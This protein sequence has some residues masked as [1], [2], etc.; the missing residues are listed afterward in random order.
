MNNKETILSFL[1]IETGASKSYGSNKF[2]FENEERAKIDYDDSHQKSWT[3]KESGETNPPKASIALVAD[4]LNLQKQNIPPLFRYFLDGSR[5]TYK[6]DD[7]AYNNKI[8]PIVA[9]QI[10]VAC[11]QRLDLDNF[12]KN[13]IEMHNVISMPS[14]ANASGQ[15]SNLYFNNLL[16]KVNNLDKLKKMNIK[17][18]KIL[19]YSKSKD[20]DKYE[21][22]AVAKIQDEMIELEKIVVSDLTTKKLLNT[23]AFLIKDGSL[24]YKVM[25]TGD[26]RELAKIK[27]NYR[28]VVG[29]S[30]QFNPDLMV[31]KRGKPNASLLADLK[32]YHRTPAIKHHTGMVGDVNFSIWYIRIRDVKYSASP[33]EGI[34]KVE[35][36]LVTDDENEN[37]LDSS[38]INNISAHLINER[39]P[40]CYGSDKR[41]AN[42]LYPVHLTER[43]I[44]SRYLSDSYYLNLF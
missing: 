35:K 41:W 42:H 3:V 17:F 24:E 23:N 40:V 9:G 7:V 12:K 31:D 11:C 10:G 5:R 34:I 33:F 32:L 16:T 37:G 4:A 26:F 27:N 1:E 20:D 28:H 44:K 2:C 21:N 8:Y 15:K 29:I 22:L 38:E 14:M 30:K 25:R 6:V 36:I 19:P 39:N 13:I 18:N 43:Y